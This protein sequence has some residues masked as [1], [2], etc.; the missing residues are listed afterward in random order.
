MTTRK[1]ESPVEKLDSGQ[2]QALSYWMSLMDGFTGGAFKRGYREMTPAER[3]ME[4]DNLTPEQM[5]MLRERKGDEW[6]LD[7]GAQIEKL[8]S[9]V[10]PI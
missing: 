9:K 7:Y 1:P 2:R 8:R 4:W 3:V 6:V 5:E 10:R